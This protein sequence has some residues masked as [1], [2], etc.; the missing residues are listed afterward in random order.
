MKPRKV[1]EAEKLNDGLGKALD[2]SNKGFA[3]L[4]RMGFKAGKGVGLGKSG[5]EQVLFAPGHGQK[6]FETSYCL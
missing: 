1:L 6:L 5:R 3:M 4:Q 2:S